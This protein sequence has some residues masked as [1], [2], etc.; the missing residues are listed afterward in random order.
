M[1]FSRLGN[2][3][4]LCLAALLILI[5]L[6]TFDDASRALSRGSIQK[7]VGQWNPR[8]TGADVQFVGDQVCAQCHQRV[9][10]SYSQSPMRMAM[11][12]VGE[13]RVLVANPVLSFRNG[14]YLYLIKRK[15]KQSFYTVSDGKGSITVSILYAFGRGKA[16][17]TYVFQNESELYESRVSFYKDIAGLD[18]T[19]GTADKIP[20]S[21]KEAL[22]RR[23]SED[24]TKNC[25]ICHSGK[26]MSGGKIN[27]EKVSHGIRC[28]TCH[29][30]GGSHVDAVQLGEPGRNLIFNPNRLGG[31]E[32][33][34]DFC[35][36]CHRPNNDFEK[37]RSLQT[38]NV[39]FQPY[40]IF[41]SKC[42]SDD[43]RISC[44]A[45]HN[46]HEP[47]KEDTAY[48]DAKCLV[49]HTVQSRKNARPNSTDQGSAISC[50]VA[51][52][53]CVSCHMQKIGLVQTHFK[54]T[55]H[56]IRVVKSGAAYP[57]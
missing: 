44:T 32:L 48:Y 30:P 4:S 9:I 11:E 40:R 56:Y 20:A 19:V 47:V 50:K 29:G 43:R 10:E 41:Y 17:Q 53:D 46:P 13:S 22:G 33:S 14:P 31:D 54:F 45:C 24:E 21:L 23:L 35:A 16:G 27:L 3:N 28:E 2:R 1:Q 5:C 12:S 38:N 55:D 51:T 52:K 7:K 49:C 18:L 25:F 36:A 15:D 39:R 6:A 34:Q 8:N 26:S 42:Y 37:M 57:K